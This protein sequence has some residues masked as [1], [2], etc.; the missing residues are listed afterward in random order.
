MCWQSPAG[1]L[2]ATTL[3]CWVIPILEALANTPVL[4]A[5]QG[6]LYWEQPRTLV[7]GHL[8][9]SSTMSPSTL[10]AQKL[11]IE[12]SLWCARQAET[13]CVKSWRQ[14][15]FLLLWTSSPRYIWLLLLLSPHR[16]HRNLHRTG[17]DAHMHECPYWKE[18]YLSLW[19]H[20]TLGIYAPLSQNLPY[21]SLL[22][23]FLFFS[24]NSYHTN[25]SSPS[26]NAHLIWG[27]YV[28]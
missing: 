19:S 4:E 5:A 6:M 21:P 9:V 14:H 10:Y 3:A 26:L 13:H 8:A 1:F 18:P 2:Q 20:A 24:P 7:A 15:G 25:N 12:W 27:L 28:G 23:H 11:D 16:S 22:T 17:W